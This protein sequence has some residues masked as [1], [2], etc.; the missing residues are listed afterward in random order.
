MRPQAPLRLTVLAAS[1]ALTL[2][3]AGPAAADVHQPPLASTVAAQAPLGRT[4]ALPAGLGDLGEA[5]SAAVAELIASIK[6]DGRLSAAASEAFDAKIAKAVEAAKADA[7]APLPTAAVPDL[8]VPDTPAVA[9]PK[10]E[11][12]AAAT[13]VA[14]PVAAEAAPADL[15]GDAG[16]TVQKAVADLVDLILSTLL[17]GL[18]AIDLPALPTLPGLP[19]LPTP[20]GLPTLPSPSP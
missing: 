16:A 14:R 3:L 8:P 9:P 6:A 7:V 5:V 13:V 20:P 2:G 11:A 4:A 12:P 1:A 15:L 17:G 19:A 18:T 10:A